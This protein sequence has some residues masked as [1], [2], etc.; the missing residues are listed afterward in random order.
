MNTCVPIVII[1]GRAKSVI[2]AAGSR[3]QA[4]HACAKLARDYR[5]VHLSTYAQGKPETAQCLASWRDGR[6]TM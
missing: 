5:E 6:R 1:G 4:E 2:A 3:R